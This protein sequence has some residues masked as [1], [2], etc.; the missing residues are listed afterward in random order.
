[1]TIEAHVC[2]ISAQPTPNLTPLLDPATA[3]KRVIMVVTPDMEQRADWLEA[4]VRPRGMRVER[5]HVKDPWDL[6]QLEEAMTRLAEQEHD[7]V[8]RGT[9]ALNATGGTKP[10]SLAAYEVFQAYGLPVFYVHPE[11][12]RLVWLNPENKPPH[13]L[14]N[15]LRL[16]TFLAAHGVSIEG[17]VLNNVPNRSLLDLTG[18][19]VARV[20][21][22]AEALGTLNW[23]AGTA[24]HHSLVSSAPI[25]RKHRS[26]NQLREMVHLFES[27]GLL[28][29]RGDDRLAFCNED[30][31]FFVNGGWLE[32]HVFAEAQALR[33]QDQRIHDL[34]RSIN[35]YRYSRDKPIRNE[36]DVAL[37][38]DNRLH[39][40]ECKTRVFKDD[41][42]GAGGDALYKIDS[43]SATVGGTQAKGM[44]V[45][46]RAWNEADKRRA[47]ELNIALCIGEQLSELRHHLSAWMS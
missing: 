34:G 33:K 38:A 18:D 11:R 36:L 5:C 30:A 24:D 43:I 16:D 6:E 9:L 23:L 46:Y 32:L 42:G 8:S 40:I 14:D 12:D 27:A 47:G 20:E 31:R 21:D 41:E 29:L 26:R 39:V 44:I 45:S 15:R 3:P 22:W 19:L 28:K 4:I 37:L 1:M 10:M 2:L 17:D 13:D 7:L 35:V 25:P